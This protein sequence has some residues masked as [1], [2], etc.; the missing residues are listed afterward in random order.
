M[1]HPSFTTPIKP[2]S[3]AFTMPG[4]H[5]VRSATLSPGPLAY[6]PAKPLTR[7]PAYTM[8]GRH[9]D[10]EARA[11]AAQ[12]GPGAYSGDLAGVKFSK[13]PAYTM[14]GRTPDPTRSSLQTP[15]SGAYSPQ[16]ALPRAAAFTMARRYSEKFDPNAPAPGSYSPSHSFTKSDQTPAFTIPGRTPDPT[17]NRMSTPGSG[18]YSPEK[19]LPRAAA[20]TM[21]RRYASKDDLNAPAPGSYSPSHSFTKTK[22]AVAV[23]GSEGKDPTPVKASNPGPGAYSVQK[24]LPNA[25][26]YSMASRSSMY[27]PSQTPGPGAY[28][29]SN[30]PLHPKMAKRAQ[31]ASNLRH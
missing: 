5:E 17:R 19:P 31:S 8:P 11:A 4:K 29:A 26:A 21:A 10:P 13:S 27:S 6:S 22:S 18:A 16:K 15:G 25:P 14:P 12:P 23:F 3:P 2:R 1:D 20:F 28:G 9:G 24:P 30:S 7:S